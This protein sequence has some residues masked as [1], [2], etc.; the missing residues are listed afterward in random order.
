MEN[1]EITEKLAK[2][3]MGWKSKLID[4][5]AF[6]QEN[7]WVDQNGNIKAYCR[8]WKPLENLSNTEMV[9][10]RMAEINPLN[11]LHLIRYS[12]NRCYAAFGSGPFDKLES[13]E[14]NGENCM[15]EAI[16]L[17]AREFDTREE[18]ITSYRESKSFY[19]SIGYVV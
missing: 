13:A 15:A 12:Y 10:K 5:S 19:R 4:T 18:A 17:A 9:I 7:V 8:K 6:S 14:A 3:I 1:Q 2:T 16:C 11:N